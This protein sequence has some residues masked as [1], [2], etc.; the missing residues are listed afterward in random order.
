MKFSDLVRK[1]RSV[2]SYEPGRAISDD[3]LKAIFDEVILSPSSFNLQHW[4]FIVVRDAAR[5]QQLRAAA[6]NQAQVEEASAVVLVCGKLDAYRDVSTIYNEMPPE[7]HDRMVAM[8]GGIYDDNS[9]MQRDEAIRGASLAAMSLMY[10]AQA[11]GYA[12]GPMIGFDPQQVSELLELGPNYLPVMMIVMGTQ[13][14]EPMPRGYRRPL[15]EV[16]RLETLNGPG[17]E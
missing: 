1:R 11:R 4:T 10:A 7:V 12:T 15:P 9:V 16:V 8:I 13:K 6:M 2:R 5:K 3:E 17:L 14:D